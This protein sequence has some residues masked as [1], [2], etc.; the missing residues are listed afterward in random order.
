MIVHVSIA[1]ALFACFACVPGMARAKDTDG[2]TDVYACGASTGHSFMMNG[3]GWSSDG[4]SKGVIVLRKRNADYDLL[5]GDATGAKFS[6]LEDGATI[7]SREQEGVLQVLVVYPTL[8][9]ETFLFAAPERG[10]TTVAW[11]SSKRAGV[12]DRV[13]A[14]VSS[15]IVR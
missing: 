3:D 13:S 9:I 7:A 14:F 5:I 1:A 10:R 11:T 15:C 12:A 6:A 2:W 4:I 8:T